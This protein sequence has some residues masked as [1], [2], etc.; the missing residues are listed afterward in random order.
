MEVLLFPAALLFILEF[1]FSQKKEKEEYN[2]KAAQNGESQY[3]LPATRHKILKSS[4]AFY[5]HP[6]MSQ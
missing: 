5:I 3:P 4:I 6:Q 1:L 2:R